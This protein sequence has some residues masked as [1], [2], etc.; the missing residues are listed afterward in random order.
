[1]KLFRERFG[2]MPEELTAAGFKWAPEAGRVYMPVYGP[3]GKRRGAQLRSYNPDARIKVIAHPESH[4]PW[5]AWYRLGTGRP[6]G[7]HE[8]LTL[9]VVEDQV[10][11]VKTS[12]HFNTVATLG[13]QLTPDRVQELAAVGARNVLFALDADATG[14]AIDMMRENM[15]LFKHTGV[16]M[17]D[18]DF[19]DSEDSEIIERVNA[20]L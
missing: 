11:A 2:L 17:L 20:A 4:A 16:V 7:I 10:S 15:L 18:R 9:V 12:R 3:M 1:M 6:D 8:P 13:T 5:Q 19:K 14:K